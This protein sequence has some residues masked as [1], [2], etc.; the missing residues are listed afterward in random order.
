MWTELTMQPLIQPWKVSDNIRNSNSVPPGQPPWHHSSFWAKVGTRVP[1][2]TLTCAL[3]T[4]LCLYDFQESK[5]SPLP[6][7]V[8]SLLLADKCHFCPLLGTP[9]NLLPEWLPKYSISVLSKLLSL[10]CS[11][12]TKMLVGLE[13]KLQGLGAVFLGVEERS[14]PLR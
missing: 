13:E 8:N 6:Q 2:Q 14:I 9:L 11:W 5:T 1:L 12:V 3:L 7:T 4:L 10:G